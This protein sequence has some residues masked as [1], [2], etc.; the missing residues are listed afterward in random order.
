MFGDQNGALR[1]LH[2]TLRHPQDQL[3]HALADVGQIR[4]T[5]SQQRFTQA[6]EEPGGRHRGRIPG[7]GRALAFGQQAMG[8]FK[9]GRVFEQF[10]VGAEDLGLG[11]AGRLGLQRLQRLVCRPQATGQCGTFEGFSRTGFGNLKR[12]L[13]HLDN[14]AERRTRRRAD[15]SQYGGRRRRRS[16]LADFLDRY[17]Q[18]LATAVEQQRHQ[19]LDRRLGIF[20]RR[21]HLHA[22][23]LG[24][25]QRHDRHKRLGIGA[26]G[27]LVQENAGTEPLR[28][29]GK[30]RRRAGVQAAGIGQCHWLGKQRIALF[31]VHL[32]GHRPR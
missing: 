30:H 21:A 8:L 17:R 32:S 29:L 12:W 28:R 15:A 23:A 14:L 13:S 3:E 16:G 7:K 4:R 24:G 31:L 27:L 22:V 1:Q 2:G 18:R 10:L 11:T 5:L 9:Q 19:R 6:F 20:P 26:Q 25:L